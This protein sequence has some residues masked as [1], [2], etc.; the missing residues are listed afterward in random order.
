[1]LASSNLSKRNQKKQ[2]NELRRASVASLPKHK[3]PILEAV[4]SARSQED[5]DVKRFTI[6]HQYYRD[7]ICT[8]RNMK[9]GYLRKVLEGYKNISRCTSEPEIYDL[10]MDIKSIKASNH[11]KKYFSKVTPDTELKEFDAGRYRGFF[12]IDRAE[13]IVQ[14]VAVDL[15][16]EDKKQTRQ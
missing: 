14:I 6:G 7:D 16:P 12:F 11:Y 8:V 2:R 4:A 13:K 15:H 9:A 3:Q 1:M 5:D 10:P